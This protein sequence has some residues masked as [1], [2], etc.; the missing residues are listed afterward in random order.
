MAT[1]TPAT[2]PA[3]SALSAFLDQRSGWTRLARAGLVGLAL[4]LISAETG[5]DPP[6]KLPP[7][8]AIPINAALGAAALALRAGQNNAEGVTP[9]ETKALDTKGVPK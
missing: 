9:A 1:P 7:S 6:I 2:P 8:I 5:S 3:P 4:A